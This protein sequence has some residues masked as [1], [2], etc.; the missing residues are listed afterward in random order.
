MKK[1]LTALATTGL[2]LGASQASAN[3]LGYGFSWSGNLAFTSNY[4]FQGASETG[5]RPALQGGFDV[6][7]ESGLY[8]GNWNS[9]VRFGDADP[10]YLEVDVYGGFA[11]DITDAFGID[12]G[13]IHYFYPGAGGAAEFTEVYGGVTGSYQDLD[14]GLYVIYETDGD[15][16][17]YEGSLEYALPMETFLFG[18]LGYVDPDEGDSMVYWH[19]GAGFSFAG[20]DFSVMYG[21]ND[22]SGNKEQWAFTVGTEF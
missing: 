13:V 15:Y 22:I 3:D 2:L 14:A 6:E 18:S 1:M 21:D 9:S 11:T 20:L 5:G 16:W 4:I 7:H 12:L 17:W 19:L 8:V 10:S